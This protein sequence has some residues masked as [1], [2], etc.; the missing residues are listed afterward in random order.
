MARDAL[1][2][3][4]VVLGSE[5]DLESLDRITSILQQELRELPVDSV[6]R[7]LG[8][9]PPSTRGDALTVGALAVRILKNA[10][11]LRALVNTV[12]SWLQR[13]DRT[14]TL[15]IDGDKL[16][17]TGISS[18]TEERLVTAWIERHAPTAE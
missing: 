2:E 17:L 1:V 12:R 11:A 4:S 6:E 13:R 9:G 8:E 7:L 10:A 15:E 3:V 5:P 18:E 14:A 16:A